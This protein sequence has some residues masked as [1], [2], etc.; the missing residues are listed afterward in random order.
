MIGESSLADG[1]DSNV[2]DS[3]SESS[4]NCGIRCECGALVS[5]IPPNLGDVSWSLSGTLS[6]RAQEFL[7]RGEVIRWTGNNG[8]VSGRRVCWWAQSQEGH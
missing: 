1:S 6:V 2:L 7:G 5:S 3:T 4:T 8:N